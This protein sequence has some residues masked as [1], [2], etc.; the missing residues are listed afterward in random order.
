MPW[1]LT[2]WSSIRTMQVAEETD[3]E[4]KQHENRR[5]S[6]KKAEEPPDKKKELKSYET[7]T[8]YNKQNWIKRLTK[9]L[10][11]RNPVQQTRHQER[12]KRGI[13]AQ[14]WYTNI[15]RN[16]KSKDRQ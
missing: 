12:K 15:C 8:Q 3:G 5:S 4:S 7:E 1:S 2:S 10:W 16:V 14:M 13:P 6:T 9:K 11:N